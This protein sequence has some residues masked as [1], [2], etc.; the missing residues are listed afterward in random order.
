MINFQE[1]TRFIK[2]KISLNSLSE[3]SWVLTGQIINVLL[4]FLIIKQLTRLGTE[5]YGVYALILTVNLLIG[6]LLYGPVTQAFIRFYH[7][8]REA[9][10]ISV[11]V[12]LMNSFVKYSALGMFGLGIVII[13][14]L[15]LSNLYSDY[16]ILSLAVIFIITFKSN[17]FYSISLNIIRKRKENSLL[18]NM[19]RIINLLLLWLLFNSSKDSLYT[20]LMLFGTTSIL[21]FSIKYKLF[22]NFHL[23]DETEEEINHLDVRNAIISSLKIY[24]FPFIIWGIT[25]WLQSN[26]EKWILANYLSTADVGIY[27]VMMT[28]VSALIILPNNIITEF[29]TPIIFQHFSDLSN[30]EKVNGG[31]KIINIIVLVT[32][33]FTAF[34]SAFTFFWGDEIILLISSEAFTVYSFLLPLFCIGT[35]LFYV[36][37]AMCNTGMALNV[38]RKYLLPKIIAGLLSVILNIIF[39]INYGIIGVA[40]AMLVVGLLYSVHIMFINVK[41]KD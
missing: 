19:E 14:I 39:I 31:H 23:G 4:N 29:S 27:A 15:T 7:E 24:A 35:G 6:S 25:G 21:F 22:S 32:I 36:G 9:G 1:T 5:L 20:V 37:Q 38:P 12:K 8:N 2:E 28:L 13:L 30:H 26:S 40:Y 10:R 33:V 34:A 11:Y 3:I 18:Q 16:L 41:L 17:E